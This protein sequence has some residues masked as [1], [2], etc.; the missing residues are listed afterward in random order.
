[1]NDYT[2]NPM[3]QPEPDE[4]KIEQENEQPL[5]PSP[6]RRESHWIKVVAILCVV[7]LAAL[8]LWP[9]DEPPTDVKP[10]KPPI[11]QAIEAETEED[12]IGEDEFAA[13]VGE[14]ML[15]NQAE[16]VVS[17]LPETVEES[18][19]ESEDGELPIPVEPPVGV[20]TP[21]PA[22][23]FSTPEV[24]IGNYFIQVG[25][26]SQTENAIKLSD[27]LHA[28][29]PVRIVRAPNGWHRVQVGPFASHEAASKAL[30]SLK[31]IH[32]LDGFITKHD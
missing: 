18:D 24:G 20:E 6:S 14:P 27:T 1:M 26:F 16:E 4:Q 2:P 25:S 17:T 23:R 19:D 8:L 10:G 5:A 9:A 32:K 31:Q 21:D 3:V 11:E 15:A 7:G 30:V 22:P 13:L 29:W 28:T 12:S